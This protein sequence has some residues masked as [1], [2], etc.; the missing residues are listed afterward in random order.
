MRL[1][2]KQE[3]ENEMIR[4]IKN[5]YVLYS[6]TTGKRLGTFRTKKGALKRE[7]QIQ[8]FKNVKK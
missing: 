2:S 1:W 6:R 3:G 5:G 4:K 7:Q 8:Y